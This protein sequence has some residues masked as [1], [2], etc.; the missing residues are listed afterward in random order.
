MR[1]HW[2]NIKPHSVLIINILLFFSIG[3]NKGANEPKLLELPPATTTGNNKFGCKLNGE[4]FVPN[5]NWAYR[6]FNGPFYGI[7]KGSFSMVA[8]NLYD[9]ENYLEIDLRIP[10]GIFETGIYENFAFSDDHGIF[11]DGDTLING[12]E[13]SLNRFYI[14]DTTMYRKFEITRLDLTN[15]I[16]SGLF[17]FTV[18]HPK[19]QKRISVTEGRFDYNGLIIQ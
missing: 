2:I 13:T 9:F 18:V 5:G 6:S 1:L 11:E 7:E 8:R 17:D 12:V 14:T 4:I 10:D 15:H 3:C 16:V 19:T